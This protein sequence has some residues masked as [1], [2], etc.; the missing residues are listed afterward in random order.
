[1]MP[2]AAVNVAH[3]RHTRAIGGTFEF[4]FI[5]PKPANTG[6]GRPKP[7]KA[8]KPSRKTRADTANRKSATKPTRP[9]LTDEQNQE[10]RRVRAAEKRQR[11][12]ELDLCK[13]CPNK[14]IK[15]QTRCLDCAEKHRRTRRDQRKKA[16]ASPLVQIPATQTGE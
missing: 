15:G 14:A 8:V 3:P 10:L 16:A 12:K 7:R 2:I 11:L 1:M 13:E 5:L 6:G 9:R 4:T